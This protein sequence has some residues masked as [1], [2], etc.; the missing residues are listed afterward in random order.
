MP[1]T[2]P[3]LA[4]PAPDRELPR[5][6]LEERIL[7]LL[8][9]NNVAVIATVNGDGSPVCPWPWKSPR[10]WPCEVPAGGQVKVPT[11]CSCRP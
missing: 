2:N 6:V 3:W 8:S 9:A 7:N 5:V 10:W 1:L 4:G 11:L